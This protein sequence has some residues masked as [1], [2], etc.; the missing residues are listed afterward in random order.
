VSYPVDGEA[1]GRQGANVNIALARN[2]PKN[3]QKFT[4]FSIDTKNGSA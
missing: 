4:E 2:K 1:Q 3:P